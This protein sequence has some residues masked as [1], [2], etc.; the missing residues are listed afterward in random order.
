MLPSQ[1]LRLTVPS[2]AACEGLG[3]LSGSHTLQAGLP[4]PSPAG[5]APLCWPGEVQGPLS[6]MLQA[7][8]ALLISCAT[9][10]HHLSSQP[11]SKRLAEPTLP[12]S[13]SGAAYPHWG[14]QGQLHCTA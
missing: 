4:M 1:G 2:A 7:M 10:I 3:Q 11:H 13:F 8:L 9:P 14:H 12:H 5:P 6:Q